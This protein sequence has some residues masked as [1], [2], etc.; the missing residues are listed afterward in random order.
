MSNSSP[1]FYYHA[2]D[3]GSWAGEPQ[4]GTIYLIFRTCCAVVGLLLDGLGDTFLSLLIILFL[5][6]AVHV[7]GIQTQSGSTG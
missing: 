2:S 4:L 5:S 1:L 7:H 6:I 3:P